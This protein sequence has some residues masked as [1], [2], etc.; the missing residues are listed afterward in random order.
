MY[1]GHIGS[2]NVVLKKMV[3]KGRG[4]SVFVMFKR[5]NVVEEMPSSMVLSMI[6]A[7]PNYQVT[8]GFVNDIKNTM[9]EDYELRYLVEYD[10]N[11][12][13]CNLYT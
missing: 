4:F 9:S 5:N 11:K 12:G 10:M 13:K 7:I 8:Y 2:N 1:F 6:K 3:R